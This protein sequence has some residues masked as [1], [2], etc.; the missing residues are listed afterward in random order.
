MSQPKDAGGMGFRLL[1]D[2]NLV[3]LANQGWRL[4]TKPDSLVG[5]IYKVRYFSNLNFLC[6]KLGANSSYI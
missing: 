1:Y 2:F 4:L 3:M 5:R 6:A